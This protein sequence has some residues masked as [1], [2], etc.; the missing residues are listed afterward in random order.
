MEEVATSPPRSPSR[1]WKAFGDG[2]EVEKATEKADPPELYRGRSRCRALSAFGCLLFICY[3]VS[4]RIPGIKAG[5]RW[6]AVH[7]RESLGLHR[8]GRRAHGDGS[9]VKARVIRIGWA[10]FS[11][12]YTSGRT[13]GQLARSTWPG[14]VV[15][16][17]FGS[18]VSL[19][20]RRESGCIFR[21]AALRIR[22]GRRS[23]SANRRRSC[24][25]RSGTPAAD[26]APV[27]SRRRHG[28]VQRTDRSHPIVD[29]IR[30]RVGDSLGYL[31]VERLVESTDASGPI[32]PRLFNRQISGARRLLRCR[33]PIANPRSSSR[34]A[35]ARRRFPTRVSS[36]Q[37]TN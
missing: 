16:L 29:Q 1:C 35:S 5:T 20:A 9:C 37:S 18:Q 10:I 26:H 8:L 32:S 2:R 6:H 19:I 36:Q 15:I 7:R 24:S 3:D 25:W 34:C 11:T 23:P 31:S 14:T 27:L 4:M 22:R 33:A 12:C 30:A 28:D 13:R 21:T 17:D